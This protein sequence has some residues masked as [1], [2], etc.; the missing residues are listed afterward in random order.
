V[1]FALTALILYLLVAGGVE[2]GRMIYISQVL[3]DAARGAARE[4]SVTPI[5]VDRPTVGAMGDHFYPDCMPD[6]P[7]GMTFEDALCYHDLEHSTLDPP[8]PLCPVPTPAVWANPERTLYFCDSQHTVDVRRQIWDPSLLVVDITNCTGATADAE[9]NDYF[10]SLPVVNRSLR[11]AFI[12]ETLNPGQANEERRILRYPGALVST[13]QMPGAPS[14]C[15]VPATDLAVQIY[16]VSHFGGVESV[17]PVPLPVITEVR[18]GPT[19]PAAA[20]CGPFNLDPPES[21]CDVAIPRGLAAVGVNYPFQSA[22][23]SGFRSG[24]FDANGAPNPNAGNPIA[25]T[26]PNPPSA[27][28]GVVS[29][30]VYSGPAGLGNQYAFGVPYTGSPTVRPYRSLLLGQAIYR[31]EVIQ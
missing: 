25:S 1:E 28:A 16:R 19:D 23:L 4:L 20:V 8:D 14:G 6:M 11:P 13:G 10:D 27:P 12:A 26:D 15:V 31:R 30:L 5:P 29:P 2:L 24:G 9:V 3:Q 7:G 17:D 18:T 22:A 21:S